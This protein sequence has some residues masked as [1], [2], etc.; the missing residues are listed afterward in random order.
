MVS[1]DFSSERVGWHLRMPDLSVCVSDGCRFMELSLL[2]CGFLC[3]LFC[4]L[5]SLMLTLIPRK[6][7]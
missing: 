1:Q 3:I 7:S 4:R 6:G 5:P 2:V